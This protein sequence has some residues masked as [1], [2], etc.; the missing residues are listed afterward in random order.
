MFIIIALIGT[1]VQPLKYRSKSRLLITQPDTAADAYAV[2][3]SN[4]Y[5]GGLISEV[6]YSG[7]FLETL[8]SSDAVFDRNYFS[9]TYKQNL[10][11]WKQTVFARSGGDSGIIEIEIYHTSPSEARQISLAVN[12]IIVSGQGPYKFT[13]NQTKISTIDQPVISTFP[14]KPNIP[15]NLLAGLIFG[16]IFGLSYVYMFPESQSE[17]MLKKA[18]NIPEGLT[19]KEPVYQMPVYQ[20]PSPVYQTQNRSTEKELTREIPPVPNNLPIYAYDEETD[21]IT[22]W[23][24]ETPLN[25]QGNINNV[26]GE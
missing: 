2:A 1:L 19:A 26:L 5:I 8:N 18:K 21:E 20:E 7:A 10:K 13:N 17:R 25:F 9:G 6:I 15:V 11:K 23:P 12:N 22:K 24:E 4:Q 3:R 14:V 16:I